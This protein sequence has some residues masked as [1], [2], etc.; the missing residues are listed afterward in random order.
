VDRAG[1]AESRVGERSVEEQRLQAALAERGLADDPMFADLDPQTVKKVTQA[2]TQWPRLIPDT[3]R[4]RFTDWARAS[5]DDAREFANRVEFARGEW[6]MLGNQARTSPQFAGMTERQSSTA[7][8]KVVSAMLDSDGLAV[9]M[10]N[11]HEVDAGVI[12]ADPRS[13]HFIE[14]LTPG[15]TPHAARHLTFPM[16]ETPTAE[17]YH[18]RKHQDDL[19]VRER[20]MNEPVAAYARSLRRTLIEGVLVRDES[21]GDKRMLHIEREVRNDLILRAIVYVKTDGTAVVAT[22]GRRT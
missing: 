19:P 7:A 3:L 6:Q 17:A 9:Y 21:V 13:A 12:A 5:S 20:N 2:L 1:E 8:R 4:D 22:Y 18:A 14:G 16:W 15:Q 11:L 10:S